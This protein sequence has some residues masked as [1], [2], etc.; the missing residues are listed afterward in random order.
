MTRRLFTIASLISLLLCVATAALWL[1]SYDV[2]DRWISAGEGWS[3]VEGVDE[4]TC[5]AISLA[6]Y[7]GRFMIVRGEQWRYEIGETPIAVQHWSGPPIG[8]W[9]AER[10]GRDRFGLARLNAV[11]YMGPQFPPWVIRVYGMPQWPIVA[12]CLAMPAVRFF[13]VPFAR[14]ARIRQRLIAHLC[15]GCG[16]DLRATPGRCPECG[17]EQVT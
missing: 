8:D 2:E 5:S 3:P 16:Y 12:L 6:S 7:R 10:A 4:V 15:P 13:V 14:R 11:G 17:K 1:R 9:E